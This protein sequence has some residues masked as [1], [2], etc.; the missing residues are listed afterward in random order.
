MIPN[1]M[2]NMCLE[3]FE[4]FVFEYGLLSKNHN[5]FIMNF[6]ANLFDLNKLPTMWIVLETQ[7][8]TICMLELSRMVSQ[9]KTRMWIKYYL[10]SFIVD[11]LSLSSSF[12]L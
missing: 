6:P 1:F 9:K 12:L 7:S 4:A 10:L 8:T 11:L 2:N 5:L 3:S